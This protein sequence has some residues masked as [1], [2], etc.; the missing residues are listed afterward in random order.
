MPEF[1]TYR[2][3]HTKERDSSKE[4][5]YLTKKYI[6]HSKKLSDVLAS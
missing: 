1:F 4:K 5:K 2:N 3:C 6:S